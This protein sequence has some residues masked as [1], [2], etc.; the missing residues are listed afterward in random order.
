MCFNQQSQYGKSGLKEG[1][2]NIKRH[3][4]LQDDI[5]QHKTNIDTLHQK[6]QNMEAEMQKQRQKI[7][8]LR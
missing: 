6:Y 5:D 2:C 7:N 3:K 4:D 1:T 8:E